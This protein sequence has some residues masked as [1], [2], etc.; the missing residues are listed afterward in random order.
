MAAPTNA[1]KREKALANTEP[2]THGTFRTSRDVRLESEMRTKADVRQPFCI[3]GCTPKVSAVGL[4]IFAVIRTIH[5]P[6]L[7]TLPEFWAIY[8]AP[9]SVYEG[10][11]CRGTAGVPGTRDGKFHS[12][13]SR[14]AVN[15]RPYSQG[16][17]RGW[18]PGESEN[19]RYKS[20]S[21]RRAALQQIWPK[22]PLSVGRRACLGKSPS[23][24]TTLQHIR[25]R[26]HRRRSRAYP[27]ATRPVD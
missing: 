22:S 6:K 13:Y 9:I 25:T 5:S 14:S 24:R 26:S 18:L 8:R 3:Y 2:S 15:A 1:A 12:G 4:F 7:S 21:R 20:D 16:S 10:S 19:T 11:C 17:N 23:N 27:L